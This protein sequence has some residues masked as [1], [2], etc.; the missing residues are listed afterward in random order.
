MP[1]GTGAT[2]WGSHVPPSATVVAKHRRDARDSSGR[3]RRQGQFRRALMP[4]AWM[5]PALPVIIGYGDMA[6]K[7][8]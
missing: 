1:D 8:R 4:G 3:W 5:L 6:L 7:F 2:P